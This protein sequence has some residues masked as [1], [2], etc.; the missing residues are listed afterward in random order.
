VVVN[1]S[2]YFCTFRVENVVTSVDVPGTLLS[3]YFVSAANCGT[4]G[5]YGTTR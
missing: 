3:M 2:S 1:E 4:S 5:K